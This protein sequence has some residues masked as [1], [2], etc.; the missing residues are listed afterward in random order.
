MAKINF[1][2]KGVPSPEALANILKKDRMRYTEL[3]HLRRPIICSISFDGR[4]EVIST[5]I[6][7]SVQFWDVKKQEVKSGKDAPASRKK[8]NDSLAEKKRIVYD[9]IENAQIQEQYIERKQLASIF[10]E[11]KIDE[12]LDTLEAVFNKFKAE[13][14]TSEGFSVKHRTAQKYITLMN[15]MVA[16]QT[17]DKFIPKRIT[18]EWV[19]KFKKFLLNRELNDNSVAKYITGLK[20][21]KKYL[22]SIGIK[23]PAQLED[24]KVVERDQIV[25]IL[26]MQELEVLEQFEFQSIFHSQVRDV[27]LFQC[28]TGQRY[29]DIEQITRN[30]ITTKDG[31]TVWLLSTQKTDE[32][33][34]IPINKK[35]VKILESYKKLSTPLPRFTNQYFNRM[36]KELAK[37]AGLSRVV[38]EV[39]F[40]NNQKKEITMPLHDAISS[41]IARKSFISLSTQKGIPERFVRDISGH[42]SERSFKKYLNLGNSHLDAILKA[43]D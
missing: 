19:D 6:S 35:A 8:I 29:S 1:Y 5:Q 20:T 17:D 37:E 25:N 12:N 22:L 42:K 26:E 43:W 27:F 13:H 10:R 40:H 24:V 38:K 16:F 30:C 39:S 11:E 33:L 34:V 31:F 14:R 7:I 2:L 23:L 41:H 28:Y 15:H 18:N 21:L 4:R 3:V 36:L 32:N 9:I